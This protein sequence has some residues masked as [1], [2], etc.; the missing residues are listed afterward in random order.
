ME[1]RTDSATDHPRHLRNGAPLQPYRRPPTPL[2]FR[3]E[4]SPKAVPINLASYEFVGD[5]GFLANI[6]LRF[7]DLGSHEAS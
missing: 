3:F 6:I 5:F 7:V 4:P 1:P 2:N